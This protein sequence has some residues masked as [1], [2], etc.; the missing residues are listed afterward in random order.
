[1][2][3]LK[4]GM[5][6]FKSIFKTD[7]LASPINKEKAYSMAVINKKASL[8]DV[9]KHYQKEALGL[10]NNAVDKNYN[11]TLLEYPN[12][13]CAEHK[14]SVVNYLKS[15]DFDVLFNDEDCVLV[16]WKIK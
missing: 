4:K 9:L 6:V 1:M 5:S 13:L 14:A 10:I 3:I 7:I 16:S 11:R 12:W 2:N 15:L 8:E